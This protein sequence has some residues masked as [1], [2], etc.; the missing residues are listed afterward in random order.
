MDAAVKEEY[1]SPLDETRILLGNRLLAPPRAH[2]SRVAAPT[3]A[4]QVV[5]LNLSEAD[6]KDGRWPLRLE[7]RHYKQ[8]DPETG[9]VRLAATRLVEIRREA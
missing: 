5:P 2:F 9:D 8:Q 6:F 7:V 3:G 1:L 4:E